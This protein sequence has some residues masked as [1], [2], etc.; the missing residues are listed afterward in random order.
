MSFV[1]ALAVMAC[2]VVG[3]AVVSELAL[4]VAEWRERRERAARLAAEARDAGGSEDWRE[5]VERALF[6]G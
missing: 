3:S 6:R 2:C 4:V 1:T 5:A